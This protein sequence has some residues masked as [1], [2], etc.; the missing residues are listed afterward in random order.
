MTS[1]YASQSQGDPNLDEI[2]QKL[3]TILQN[4]GSKVIPRLDLEPFSNDLHNEP[5][6]AGHKELWEEQ[7]R[8]IFMRSNY[9]LIFF[10]TRLGGCEVGCQID[11]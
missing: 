11:W 9:L 4:L 3:A 5:S 10:L 8:A 2:E 6:E 7:V 1:Q